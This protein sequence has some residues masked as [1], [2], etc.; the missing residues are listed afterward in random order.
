M[1]AAESVVVLVVA[2]VVVGFGVVLKGSVVVVV[3]VGV[4]A[5]ICVV[6]I[7]TGDV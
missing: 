5:A 2:G 3:G 1:A 4:V 7:G 6:G